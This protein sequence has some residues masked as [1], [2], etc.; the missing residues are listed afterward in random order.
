MLSSYFIF[1]SARI[2]V[3]KILKITIPVVVIITIIIILIIIIKCR[4]R[5]QRNCIR[6]D[7]ASFAVNVTDETVIELT[8]QSSSVQHAFV[9]PAYK[10]D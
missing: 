8:P 5:Q 1:F 9:K 6:Q 3:D 10:V 2:N 4:R 7:I